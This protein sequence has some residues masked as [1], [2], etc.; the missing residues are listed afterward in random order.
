MFRVGKMY[1]NLASIKKY[2]WLGKMTPFKV[3]GNTYFVGTYQASCHLIDTGDGLI[4]IDPGY[5][6]TAYLVINSI[7]QLGFKPQDIKYIINTHWHGDH[8]EATA[9]FADLTGAKTL[10]G[11]DD[12]E[13]AKPYFTPDIIVDD[14]D[15]LSLGNITI[16]FVHTPGHT[17]GTISPFYED[18]DGERTCRVG[19]F[20]GAGLNTMVPEEFEFDGCR[21]AYF[22]SLERLKQEKV[23]V[24]IGNHTWNN[25]TLGTYERLAGTGR[26]D[27]IDS[28]IWQR[29]L[30]DYKR[31]LQAIIDA[32]NEK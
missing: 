6:K 14:G 5:T 7:Y 9:A 22:A 13:N 2:P 11:R 27:F 4:M 12:V 20:G 23:D 8:T 26:N 10:L 30:D 1:E 3:F 29:F 25:D 31:R 19:M 28:E 15:L 24:F 17:K 32:E 16:R 21:D 18:T